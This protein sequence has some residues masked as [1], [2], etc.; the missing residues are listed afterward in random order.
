LLD[1]FGYG[2]QL[3]G[4]NGKARLDA[5]WNGSPSTFRI[6]ALDGVLTL[7]ARDGQLTDVEP[8]AGRV[9]GLLSIAQLPRRLTLDFRDF[10]SKG[11]AFDRIEGDVHVGGG[12]AR[13]DNMVID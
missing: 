6:D 3:S 4:G 8:G 13:S 9:L 5:S 12:N 7:A 2:G 1:G 10:F 11:F